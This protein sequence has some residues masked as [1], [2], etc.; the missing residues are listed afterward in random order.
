VTSQI[1]GT[2]ATLSLLGQAIDHSVPVASFGDG[3]VV[4]HVVS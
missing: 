3:I 2:L 4:R 1:A